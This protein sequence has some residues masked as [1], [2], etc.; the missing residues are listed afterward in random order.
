[1]IESRNLFKLQSKLT[2]DNKTIPVKTLE[3]DYVLSWVLIGIAKTELYN[4]L[5]FKGG[6][7]LK[8]FYFPDYRFSEDL[9]FTL[10]T[11]ISIEDLEKMLQEVYSLVFEASNI[12]LSLKNKGLHKNGYT[13]FINFSGPL[14]ADI[15]RGEIK[16]DFT[17]NEN[18]INQPIVKRLL[19]GYDEYTDIPQDIKLKVYPLEE[20]FL[21][22]Y[23]CILDK[24]RNEPRDVYDLWYL[25]S[26]QCLEFEQV[27]FD[28]KRKGSVKG[29]TTFNIID[30]L[31]HKESNYRRLWEIRLEK[32]MIDLPS[33]DKV[34][35]GLKKFL[36]PINSVFK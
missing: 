36:K 7:A 32:H 11:D 15:T 1:M 25:I 30:V 28:I 31:R 29:I 26:N 9:D 14:G 8:K 33:F 27:A 24:S 13:V 2:K 21:E 22:K 6:T 12:N 19:R 18:L 17:I 10:L 5:S 4:I 35:R 23:L 16:T 3:K 34:Y 20:T